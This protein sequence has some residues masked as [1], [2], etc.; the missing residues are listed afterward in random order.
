M[1]RY[2]NTAGPIRKDDHYYIPPLERWDLE[3]ILM[4]IEQKKYFV[5]HAPRQTGKT[6]SLLALMDYLNQ[7]GRFKCLYVNVETA[8]TARGDVSRGIHSILG[9]LANQEKIYLKE[10]IIDKNWYEIF[11]K[12]SPD[13]ALN[14]ILTFWAENSSKPIILLID[15]IDSLVDDTL[16]SVLR[17]IRSG[18]TNRPNS[19]PQTIILSGVRDV[20]DYRIHRSKYQEIITGGSAFNIKAESLRM[21]NFNLDEVK[22][23][24]LQHTQETG[25]EFEDSVFPFVYELTRGQP[26]LVNA[27]AYEACFKMKQNRER[28]IVITKEILEEAKE[29]IILRR[30]THIDQLIDK[31]SE[32]RVLRIIEPILENKEELANIPTDDLQYLIDLGLILKEKNNIMISNAIYR[33][34]IPRE[35]TYTAQLTIHH[36]TP[37]YVDKKTNKLQ[38]NKLLSAFQDFYREHSEYWLKGLQYKEAGPQ[39]LLQAFLQRIINSGGIVEREYGLGRKRTDLYIRWF[40]DKFD[41]SRTQKVVVECKVIRKSKEVTIQEGILQTVEY[42]DKCG[43]EEAYLILFDKSQNKMWEDKIFQEN[44][45]FSNNT[46]SIWGM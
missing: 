4:L 38:M 5:L 18:Y 43:A 37:W 21:G 29:N 7:E 20:R 32:K 41:K 6:S 11:Q 44:R 3:E 16:I 46:I 14:A 28:S 34:I 27:L 1:K 42:K 17:Q 39:L 12:N 9:G 26:W 40:Y 22:S 23:L 13:Q 24:Y 2:F 10:D 36:E 35:I 30:D 8:Q 25:Q 15:E 45:I 19:F 31:L 33:E